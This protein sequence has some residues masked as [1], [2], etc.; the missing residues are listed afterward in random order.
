MPTMPL[1]RLCLKSVCIHTYLAGRSVCRVSRAHVQRPFAD[2]SFKHTDS[3]SFSFLLRRIRLHAD[4]SLHAAIN[5]SVFATIVLFLL[6]VS[7]SRLPASMPEI[8]IFVLLRCLRLRGWDSWY[9]RAV[10]YAPKPFRRLIRAFNEISYEH[11]F[12]FFPRA[13]LSLLHSFARFVWNSLF[14]QWYV[15]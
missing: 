10:R 11:I 5:L 13:F 6:F 4:L 9:T 12:F 3:L 8:I 15:D 7:R 1:L 14:L 2:A